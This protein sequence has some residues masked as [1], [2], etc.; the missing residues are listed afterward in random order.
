VPDFT[1]TATEW[2]S[3][4][5]WLLEDIED[6]G[7][8]RAPRGQRTFELRDFIFVIDRPSE[9][10]REQSIGLLP[11]GIGRGLNLK[12]AALE[13]LQL[14]CGVALPELTH[15]VAPALTP[16]AEDDG[17]F[18]G[19]YGKRIGGQL[20]ECYTKLIDDPGTRQAVISLW[21][22]QLDGQGGKRDH[23]CTLS[24]TFSLIDGRL[25]LSVTMRSNDAW[26][27]LP[28]DVFQ[29]SAL[30]ASL[31]NA[32]GCPVG[33]Y[34]HHAVSLHVYERD[35]PKLEQ[36]HAHDGTYLEHNG[37]LRFDRLVEEGHLD[38]R[39]LQLLA[40]TLLAWPLDDVVDDL[41]VERWY[42]EQL[43]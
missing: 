8:P 29:F 11:T 31:A 28:Y 18:W 12:I 21:N 36:L 4:Y 42:R 16:F 30:Q 38:H 43:T 13:A 15:K 27:G 1:C 22:P 2:P 35:L 7:R 10:K 23:P 33:R 6:K 19:A 26:L 17:R 32:L 20:V 25:E 40:K 24:L 39:H 14:C 5:R 37:G 41:P 3:N 34:T 9:F